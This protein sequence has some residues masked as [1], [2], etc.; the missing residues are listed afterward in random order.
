MCAS[1][2]IDENMMRTIDTSE[3]P[4]AGLNLFNQF[5]AFHCV[6]YTHSYSKVQLKPLTAEHFTRVTARVVR[7]N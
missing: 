5:A 2:R 3:C 6:Y 1:I 4:S 7:G